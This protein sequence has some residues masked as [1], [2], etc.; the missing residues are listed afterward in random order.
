MFVYIY[1]FTNVFGI[2]P[3]YISDFPYGITFLLYEIYL[4]GSLLVGSIGNNGV[5]NGNLL[6]YSCLENFMERAQWAGVHGVTKSWTR[7]SEH[8]E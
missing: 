4:S 3:S 5:G 1:L 7:L 2:I 8:L 6:Q